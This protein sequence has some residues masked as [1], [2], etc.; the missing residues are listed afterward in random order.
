M[1]RTPWNAMVKSVGGV[2]LLRRGGPS[3]ILI[4]LP[5]FDTHVGLLLLVFWCARFGRG[6]GCGVVRDPV[7][8]VHGLCGALS[9]CPGRGAGQVLIQ[10]MPSDSY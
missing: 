1:P 2:V 5:P 8:V 7:V 10:A 4:E 9:L 3:M 6:G